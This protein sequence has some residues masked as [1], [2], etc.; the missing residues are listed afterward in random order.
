M[1]SRYRLSIYP[2][3]GAE[4]AL[5]GADGI[6]QASDIVEV[7]V[8]VEAAAGRGRKVVAVHHRLGAM[9]DGAHGEA[10]LV[11][12]RRHVARMNAVED[13]AEH[14]GVLVR[15]MGPEQPKTVDLAERRPRALEEQAFVRADVRHADSVEILDG[16]R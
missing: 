5:R 6:G 10:V 8:H 14:A 1:K 13:E 12:D 2:S 3:G 9:V 15:R 11:Q 4:D 16:R 7:V